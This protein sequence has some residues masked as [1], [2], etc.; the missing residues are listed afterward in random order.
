MRT[1]K[2][3][4]VCLENKPG[5][6]AGLCKCLAQKKINIIAISVAE[7]SEQGVVRMVVDK[8]AAALKAIAE[9]G[10]M[11]CAQMDVLLVDLPNRVGVLAELAVRLASK[12]I[13]VNFVYGSTGEGRGKT[14]IVVGTPNIKSAAGAIRSRK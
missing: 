5:R 12:R 10:P 6:L 9:C 13:N 4:S 14:N 7:T 2:Q 3:I 8:P 1:A 11:T